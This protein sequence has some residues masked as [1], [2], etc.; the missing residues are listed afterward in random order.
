MPQRVTIGERDYHVRAMKNLE[1]WTRLVERIKFD[2]ATRTVSA[3]VKELTAEGVRP[4][5]IGYALRERF[6]REVLV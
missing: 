4:E 5:F 6:L 2:P 1:E 3:D